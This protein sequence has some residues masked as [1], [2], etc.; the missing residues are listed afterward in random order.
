MTCRAR[1]SMRTWFIRETA[2]R[3][4]AT[5]S[6]GRTLP[7]WDDLLGLFPETI[8]VKTGH[9][10]QAGWCQ[11]AAA[12]GRGATIYATLLGSPDRATRNTDLESLL[13]WGLAQ[14]RVVHLV[15]A[16]RTY[17]TVQLPYGRSPLPLVAARAQDGSARIGHGLTEKVVAPV[18]VPL[19]VRQ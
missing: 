11:V 10:S 17:A 6:G 13:V 7:T 14:F 8:G 3:P 2:R 16:N 18:A 4:T 9:T 12:R 15:Q 5:I 1:I 19:P